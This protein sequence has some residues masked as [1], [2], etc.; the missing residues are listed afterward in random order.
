MKSGLPSSFRSPT[1]RGRGYRFVHDVAILQLP[2]TDTVQTR[3]A[4]PR[5][6]QPQPAAE[7][8][9]RRRALWP[10]L[11]AASMLIA[12][13]V[14]TAA[15]RWRPAEWSVVVMPFTVVDS[16]AGEGLE[17]GLAQYLVLQLEKAGIRAQVLAGGPPGEQPRDAGARLGADAVLTGALQQLPAVWRVSVE[18]VRTSD[19]S[20][21]WTWVFEVANDA[22]RPTSAGP[23]DVRSRLQGAIAGQIASELARR[24]ADGSTRIPD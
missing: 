13:L 10:A 19:G 18:L 22:E 3:I 7:P 21:E 11:A 14:L 9:P 2:A 23:D 12:A 24:L 4:Q 8:K 1:V 20:R 6:V 15:M 16:V 17:P 5:I